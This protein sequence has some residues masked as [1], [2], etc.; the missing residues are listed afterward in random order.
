MHPDLASLVAFCDGEDGQ[1]RGRGIERHLAKC[2]RCRE[3]FTRIRSEKAGLSAAGHGMPA[4]DTRHGLAA[5]QSDMDRWRRDP[6]A[7]GA[8][9][10]RCRLRSQIETYLG[11]SAGS[12]LERT[13][14]PAEEL[15][16]KTSEL[17][18]V[19]LGQA[20]AEAVEDEVFAG[21]VHARS[22]GWR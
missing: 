11:T 16:G 14:M 2:E 21:F 18:A 1:D 15:L 10:L 9:Q 19:F 4:I 7:S 13:G 20:A 6:A 12:V 17:L 5:L 3:Q 8:S 22:E